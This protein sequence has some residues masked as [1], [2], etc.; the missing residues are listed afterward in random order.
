MWFQV[1][2]SPNVTIITICC[3]LVILKELSKHIH[4]THIP[5]TSE[6]VPNSMKSF[7]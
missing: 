1:E 2:F 3:I 4:V 5:K 7:W 6:L